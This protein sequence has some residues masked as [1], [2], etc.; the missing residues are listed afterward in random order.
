MFQAIREEIEKTHDVT[1]DDIGSL[2]TYGDPGEYCWRPVPKEWLRHAMAV[3]IRRSKVI[4]LCE[5]LNKRK[6]D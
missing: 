4:K 3:L 6:G 2:Y 1:L 5:R